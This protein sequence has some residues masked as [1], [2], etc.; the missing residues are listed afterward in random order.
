MAMPTPATPVRLPLDCDPFDIDEIRTSLLNHLDEAIPVEGQP[1]PALHVFCTGHREVLEIHPLAREPGFD[2][3]A[4]W[5]AVAAR[6]D[7]ANAVVVAGAQVGDGRLAAIV[8]GVEWDDGTIT[9]WWACLRGYALSPEGIGTLTD[10]WQGLRGDGEPPAP[11]ATFTRLVPGAQAWPLLPAKPP[12]PDLRA[13]LGEMPE[14]ARVPAT[15]LE[16]TDFV[17][18]STMPEVEQRG[19]DHARIFRLRGR[20]VEVWEVRGGHLPSS[21]DDLIRAVCQRGAPADAVGIAIAT[22]FEQDG[23]RLHA[24]DITAEVAG[25][26]AQRIFT[27]HKPPGATKEV[28]SKTHWREFGEVKEGKGWLGVDPMVDWELAVVGMEE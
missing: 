13:Q 19:I 23:E 11:F 7:V 27:F 12:R 14:T 20:S 15:A 28:P 9:S 10:P 8:M 21:M 22:V 6:G 25:K 16:M 2:L 18:A 3:G 24:L 1:R 5:R 26:R 4:T 17:A